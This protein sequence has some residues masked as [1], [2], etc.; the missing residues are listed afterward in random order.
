MKRLFVMTLLMMLCMMSVLAQKTI[1]WDD[2]AMGYSRMKMM[3]KPTKV[4]FYQ[5]KTVLTFNIKRPSGETIGFTSST[6]LKTK[7]KEY[8]IQSIKEMNLNEGFTIPAGSRGMDIHMIFA[9]LPLDTRSFDFEME[10]TPLKFTNIHSRNNQGIT[11]TYW[12][13]SQTGDW[14]IGFAKDNIIYDCKVWDIIQKAEK[15]DSYKFTAKCADMQLGVSVSKEKRGMRTITVNDQKFVC[16]KITTACLP[17]YP[18]S[19]TNTTIVDNN[20]RMGDSVTIIGWL[21]DMP[22]EA[23]EISNEFSV[24]V[25][26]IFADVDKFYS[27]PL[28]PD[29]Q[30]V[31]RLP[32]DNTLSFFVEIERNPMMLFVEPN[33]TYYLLCDYAN[34]Q[35]LVMGRSSR[36]TNEILN[37]MEWMM[38]S[39]IHHQYVDR[40]GGLMPFLMKND[41]IKNSAMQYMNDFYEQH[42]TLSQ[43]YKTFA[44]QYSLVD[45]ATQLMQA[46]FS[47]QNYQLPEEYVSFVTENYWNKLQQPYTMTAPNTFFRDYSDVIGWDLLKGTT[48]SFR[49]IEMIK[50]GLQ[51]GELKLTDQERQLFEKYLKEEKYTDDFKAV[52]EGENVQTYLLNKETRLMYPAQMDSLKSKGWNSTLCDIYICRD[53]IERIDNSRTQLSDAHLT[54]VNEYI[55]T[56]ALKEK[57]LATNNIY[58][59]LANRSVKADVFKSN[60]DLKNMSEGEQILRKILEP[61]K[62]KLVLIDIWGTWCTPCKEALSHSQEE[63]EYLKQ[64]DIVYLYLANNS[65]E[66]G[67]KNVIKQYNVVGDN[68]AHYNLPKAQQTAIE[69]FLNVNSFPTYKLVDTDGTILDVN[70][71]PRHLKQFEALLKLVLRK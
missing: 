10:G 30:F 54:I 71:D 42:P 33:E 51:N 49:P 41:S 23:A 70:A 24:G 27:A 34:D 12:R 47:V 65:Q 11:D 59:A 57:V 37:H 39:T 4:E 43:R 63:Y 16:N 36:L 35:T 17:D 6:K 18:I 25:R 58:A 14:A 31:L 48:F 22:K 46:R 9:P 7:G 20:F 26:S 13:N 62:G 38:V 61:Y 53:M 69:H 29:G 55:K 68:V 40:E 2:P 5:D 3:M 50:E 44:E 32:V 1:V 21:K 60:D 45:V 19:D 66:E 56:P 28:K 15:K 8:A 64:Y 67:W 52:L